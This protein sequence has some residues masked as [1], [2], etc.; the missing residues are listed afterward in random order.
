MLKRPMYR[1]W[2]KK[3]KVFVEPSEMG[4]SL[5]GSPV[6]PNEFWLKHNLADLQLSESIGLKD[7]QNIDIYTGDIIDDDWFD[8][9]GRKINPKGFVVEFGTHETCTGDYY[10][11]TAHGYYL[12]NLENNDTHSLPYH[13]SIKIIGNMFK[14]KELMNEP[15]NHS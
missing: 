14:N 7:D 9:N 13:E 15:N 5:D 1:V 12:R 10:S 3:L 2:D 11:S 8:V 4:I 6:A